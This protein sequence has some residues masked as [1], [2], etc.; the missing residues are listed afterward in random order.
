LEGA[1]ADAVVATPLGATPSAKFEPCWLM[2]VLAEAVPLVCMER[3]AK[4]TTSSIPS[5]AIAISEGF[6][7]WSCGT[8]MLKRS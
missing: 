6:K 7:R 2:D 5:E 3:A 4:E 1:A 8:G